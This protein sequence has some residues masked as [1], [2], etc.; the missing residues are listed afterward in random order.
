MWVNKSITKTVTGATAETTADYISLLISELSS[1]TDITAVSGENA[2][3]IA[4][5]LKLLFAASG[6]TQITITAYIGSQ[7]WEIGSIHALNGT[8]GSRTYR[9]DFHIAANVNAKV[10]NVKLKSFYT[11]ANS[12]NFNTDILYAI[13]DLNTELFSFTHISSTSSSSTRNFATSQTLQRVSDKEAVYIVQNRVPYVH[14]SDTTKLDSISGKILTSGNIRAD[15]ISTMLDCST[16]TG[17][18][19]FPSGSKTYYAVDDNTLIE[20]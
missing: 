18:M 1:E 7:N 19:L 3:L 5:K 12:A 11:P 8:S 17:D 10:I 9:I 6:V 13:T 20:V 14:N 16:V 15:C 4:G 2:V